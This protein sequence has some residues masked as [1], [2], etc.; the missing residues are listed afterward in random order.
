MVIQLASA[1]LFIAL[2]SYEL[3][4]LYKQASIMFLPTLIT[5][6]I[7]G[8]SLFLDF[9]TETF[10]Y[11]ERSMYFKLENVALDKGENPKP[12]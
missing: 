4:N 5:T 12:K 10:H 2:K 7:L 3:D 1:L 8:T 9:A 11:K 6:A